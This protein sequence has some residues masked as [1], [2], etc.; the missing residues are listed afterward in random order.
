MSIGRTYSDWEL[1][2]YATK[3]YTVV[4]GGFTKLLNEVK[5]FLKDKTDVL[6]T[7][8]YRDLC[9]DYH[10]SVYYKNGF[11][12]IGDSGPIMYYVTNHYTKLE[13]RQKYQKYKLKTMFPN[14]YSDIK[15]EQQILAENHIYPLWT[16]GN[17]K[18]ILNINS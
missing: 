4:V 5:N 15:T 18:F 6:I 10:D 12:F 14:S 17:Y 1:S 8:L 3:K 13:S 9:P 11:T 16:S 7:Y 2:R